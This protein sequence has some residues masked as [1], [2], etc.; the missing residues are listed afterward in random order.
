MGHVGHD[1]FLGDWSRLSKKTCWDLVKNSRA[2]CKKIQDFSRSV[3]WSFKQFQVQINNSAWGKRERGEE[4]KKLLTNR[5][6]PC[7]VREDLPFLHRGHF[8]RIFG[9]R[10]REVVRLSR[11]HEEASP[12]ARIGTSRLGLGFYYPC[13]IY[14]Q[15]RSLEQTV[16]KPIK[17]TMFCT[18]R[19]R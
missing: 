12:S 11:A 15:L 16:A 4:K 6:C 17:L 14:C 2:C 8:G 18:D 9:C 13:R 3:K 7:C 1:L 5:T 10:F 19:F